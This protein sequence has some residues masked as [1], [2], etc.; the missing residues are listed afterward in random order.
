MQID[1]KAAPAD[2]EQRLAAVA[3]V[4]AMQRQGVR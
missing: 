2:W 3:A 1:I 4:A